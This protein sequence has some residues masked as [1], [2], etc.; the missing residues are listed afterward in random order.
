MGA[1]D[2]NRCPWEKRSGAIRDLPEFGVEECQNCKLVSHEKDLRQFVD[3][4][5]GTMHAWASGYGGMLATPQKTFPDVCQRFW[6]Y[7]KLSI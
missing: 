4:A 5:S 1:S 7:L 3:Y 6:R 2:T